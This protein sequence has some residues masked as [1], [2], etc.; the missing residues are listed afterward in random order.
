MNFKIY[1]IIC[2]MSISYWGFSQVGIGN[3]NPE[4][5]SVLD[6]TNPNNK[7]LLLPEASGQD[8]MSPSPGMMYSYQN[9]IFF[10]GISGYNSITPWKFK[11]NGDISNHLFYNLDGNIGIGISDITLAPEAP[12]Q[13][14]TD[15]AV[16]LSENGTLLLGKSD[17]T[18]LIFNSSEIQSRN[19]NSA[20]PLTINENAG[21]VHIGSKDTPVNFKVS[22]KNKAVYRPTNTTYDLMPKGAIVM[23]SGTTTDIPLGWAICNGGKYATSTNKNDS[24]ISPD[25]SGRFIVTVGDNGT[26]NYEA[27]DTGGSD[28]VTITTES[29]PN[30]QHNSIDLGHTHSYSYQSKTTSEEGAG[31]AAGRHVSRGVTTK[32]GTTGATTATIYQDVVGSNLAHENRPSYYALVFLI[33]L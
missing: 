15:K 17:T 9:N 11:F 26:H 10:R 12:L 13:I 32:G 31:T 20:A 23:W 33:K 25:L 28:E 4:S 8:S 19:N 21:D 29:M 3:P 16:S 7:G 5:T 2:L 22:N 14:E 30:H 1:I 6:L 27:N 24:I 18:N